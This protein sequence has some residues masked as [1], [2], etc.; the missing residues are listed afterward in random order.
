MNKNFVHLE[1]SVRQLKRDSNFFLN[2]KMICIKIIETQ[3]KEQEMKT[4]LLEA[5]FQRDN[6]LFY[7]FDDKSDESWEESETRV[8]VESR[9]N[10]K[11]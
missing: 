9:L 6:L 7:G 4:E 2:F 3:N 10:T 8:K 5:Q 11:V 1:A